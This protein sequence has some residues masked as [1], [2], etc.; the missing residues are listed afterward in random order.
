MRPASTTKAICGY[1]SPV[2]NGGYRGSR[3]TCREHAGCADIGRLDG[4]GAAVL[5]QHQHLGRRASQTFRGVLRPMRYFDGASF[6]PEMLNSLLVRALNS[7]EVKI[8]DGLPLNMATLD[9]ERAGDARAVAIAVWAASQVT[10]ISSFDP[11]ELNV[12]T[13]RNPDYSDHMRHGW[14]K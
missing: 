7:G 9:C 14:E 3:R 1:I 5:H 13:M 4:A 8:A 2:M 12:R 10:T 11:Y 6:K